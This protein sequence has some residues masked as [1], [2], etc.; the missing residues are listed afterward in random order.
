M[1][2]VPCSTFQLTGSDWQCAYLSVPA[3][4]SEPEGPQLELATAI[5]PST[6]PTTPTTD[7]LV[8]QQGGPGGSTLDLFSG[9]LNSPNPSLAAIRAGRDIILYDQ[10]GTLYSL[11][12]LTCPEEISQT[13]TDLELPISPQESLQHS[14]AALLQCRDRLSASGVDLAVFN[15]FENAQDVEDVRR[16]LGYAHFD[17]Y[18][19]SYGTL[20]GLHALAVTPSTFRTVT[21]DAVVPAQANPNATIAQTENRA[22]EALFSACAADPA[23]A[24]AY[25]NLR[26]TFYETVDALNAVPAR[27]LLRD[28]PTHRTLQA[29]LD[30]DTFMGLIF[31]FIY[32]SEFVPALPRVIAEAHAGRYDVLGVYWPLFDLDRTFASAMYYSVMCSE[33]SDFTVADLALEGVDP[34]IARAQ[35]RDTAA[36][37]DLCQKWNV[38]ALGPKADTPVTANVPALLFSGAFDPITPP[39]FGETAAATLHPAYVFE[40]PAYGHG[41]LTSGPCASEIMLAFVKDPARRPAAACLASVTR[42][43]F[44]TPSNWFLSPRVGMLQLAV[45]QLNPSPFFVPLLLLAFLFTILLVGPVLWLVRLARGES[46]SPSF[47]ARL[48]PWLA[49]LA[50]V[51]LLVFFVAWFAFLIAG[52]LQDAPTVPLLLGAP[53]F[54]GALF[55]LPPLFVLVIL[56]LLLTFLLALR[57]PMHLLLRLYYAALTLAALGMGAWL[58]SNDLLTLL[59]S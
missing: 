54:A 37:L 18:G 47:L 27:V 8:F 50:T 13:L 39:A 46:P 33:D 42:V 38:P 11:P 28:A 16:A 17:Y 1:R 48:V 15:S 22:F 44:I 21:L 12:S 58:F 29:V 3:R 6:G 56:A 23:C 57:R 26:A 30:G 14:E 34:H 24:G 7:A 31:E 51:L 59:I 9:L 40:F 5:L 25:P 41:A 20:L 32:S 43:G 19:V 10:R 4:H 36:F 52:A 45:L 49:A 35:T 2:P 53:G 55:V